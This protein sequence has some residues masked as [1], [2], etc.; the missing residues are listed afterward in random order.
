MIAIESRTAHGV[1]PDGIQLDGNWVTKGAVTLPIGAIVVSGQQRMLRIA[2]QLLEPTSNDGLF[3]YEVLGV[4]KGKSV[5]FGPTCPVL[6]LLSAPSLMAIN[7][8]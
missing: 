6:H 8:L 3:T 5:D 7:R 2:A 1:A 4:E